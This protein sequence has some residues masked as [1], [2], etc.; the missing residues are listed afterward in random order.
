[1]FEDWIPS[2]QSRVPQF[3]SSSPL[4][5]NA[6]LYFLGRVT[7]SPRAGYPTTAT[8]DLRSLGP[9]PS[10]LMSDA[11]V[12]ERELRIRVCAPPAQRSRI[13]M[14]RLGFLTWMWAS[15]AVGS[16]HEWHS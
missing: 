6:C 2:I 10:T 8:A 4:S 12:R 15:S 9:Y 5:S 7:R 14:L 3:R 11:S 16:A 1:F 13:L